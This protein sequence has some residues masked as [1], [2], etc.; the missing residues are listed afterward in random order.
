MESYGI[1][2][3]TKCVKSLEKDVKN[4]ADGGKYF[5]NVNSTNHIYCTN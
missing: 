2:K 1:K 5:S 4:A 3:L